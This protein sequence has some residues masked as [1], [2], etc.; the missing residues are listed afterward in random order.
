MGKRAWGAAEDKLARSAA[1][2]TGGRRS[3]APTAA[4]RAALEARQAAI[5]ELLARGSVRGPVQSPSCDDRSV[6]AE[7]E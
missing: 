6:E 4:Q 3:K 1:A 5:A 2:S 7:A